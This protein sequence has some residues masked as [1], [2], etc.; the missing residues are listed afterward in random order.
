MPLALRGTVNEH[1]PCTW[2]DVTTSCPLLAGTPTLTTAETAF[3]L[4]FLEPIRPV[5]VTFAVVGLFVHALSESL[6]ALPALT[7]AGFVNAF[8]SNGTSTK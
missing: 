1:E 8:R 2:Y 5:H 4:I 7:L 6:A 3:P